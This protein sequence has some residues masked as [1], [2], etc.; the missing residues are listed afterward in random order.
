MI[1]AVYAYALWVIVTVG[2]QWKTLNEDGSPS[3]M[4]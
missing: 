4:Q 2:D 3:G 1:D